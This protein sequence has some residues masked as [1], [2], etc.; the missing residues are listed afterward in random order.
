[1]LEYALLYIPLA[2]VAGMVMGVAG[3]RD[4][5][6]GVLRGLLNAGLLTGGMAVLIFLVQLTTNPTMLS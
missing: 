3:S 4:F 2:M 1:M 6:R 5:K